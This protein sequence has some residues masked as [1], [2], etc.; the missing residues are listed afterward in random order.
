MH[1]NPAAFSILIVFAPYENAG[2][3]MQAPPWQHLWPITNHMKGLQAS[4]MQARQRQIVAL[5]C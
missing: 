3:G 1:I 4:V 2:S 5:L